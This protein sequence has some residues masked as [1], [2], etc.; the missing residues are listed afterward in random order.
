M[1][2]FQQ[3]AQLDG[4]RL[5]GKRQGQE[6]RVVGSDSAVEERIIGLLSQDEYP[7]LRVPGQQRGG[8]GGTRLRDRAGVENQDVNGPPVG[9]GQGQ[10]VLRRRGQQDLVAQHAQRQVD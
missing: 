2:T 4:Q 8:Q 7:E 3:L 5:R 6:Q 1:R 9:R 10:A